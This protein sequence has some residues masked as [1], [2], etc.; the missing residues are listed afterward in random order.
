M[1][2]DNLEIV[3]LDSLDSE[4]Q[5]EQV[6]NEA[7]EQVLNEAEELVLNETEEQALNE[8]EAVE[9]RTDDVLSS[10]RKNLP[11]QEEQEE[12]RQRTEDRKARRGGRGAKG[13]N[14][15][16]KRKIWPFVLGA[17][18]ALGAVFFILRKLNPYSRITAVETV[19]AEKQDIRQ[20]VQISGTVVT[21]EEKTYFSGITVP[22][23]SV[24]VTVG[25]HVTEGEPLL[26]FSMDQ[27]DLTKTQAQLKETAANGDYSSS[28]TKDAKSAAD[29]AEA[30]ARLPQLEQEIWAVQETI[31]QYNIMVEEKQRRMAATGMELQQALIEAT[32][33]TDEYQKLQLLVQENSYAQQND[34]EVADWKTNINDMQQLLSDLKSEKAEMDAKKSS[35]EA[36]TLN[37]GAK[38]SLSANQQQ[39]VLS[40]EDTI[41]SV[42]QAQTGVTA[43]FDGVVTKVSVVEGQT[44]QQGSELLTVASTEDV[45]VEIQIT[46]NDLDKVREGQTVT[47]EIAGKEYSGTVTKIAGNATRNSNNVPVV[48]AQISLDHPDK[49]VILGVEAKTVIETGISEGAVVL[50]YEY[51]NSDT[52]G[53]F[54]YV[55]E[56]GVL[57][58]RE[59]SIGIMT[60]SMIEIRKGV[61]AGEQVTG[62]L[63][64]GV[65]EGSTVV[66]VP[67]GT[68][69]GMEVPAQEVDTEGAVTSIPASDEGSGEN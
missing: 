57:Q 5:E 52:E 50:P 2:E 40:A 3:D 32:P 18:L 55:V 58:R 51:V 1:S 65:T 60:D 53:D 21:G 29:L 66:A 6:M 46:K 69:N 11:E 10:F 68:M 26:S 61:S 16:K 62:N 30:N 19:A 64:D 36:G 63:P 28:M 31:D 44:V 67:A 45:R 43:G 22:V 20:T 15:R 54:I 23:E 48:L 24:K 42:E 7:E 49:D 34:Q 9:A 12:G 39:S 14:R 59:V 38:Q 47:A 56:D 4:K 41:S 27:L 37:A 25:D 13:R 17:L 35:G 8:T 33:G